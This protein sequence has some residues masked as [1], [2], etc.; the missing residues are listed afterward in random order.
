MLSKGRYYTLQYG[1]LQ[2]FYVRDDG[3]V[4]GEVGVVEGFPSIDVFSSSKRLY[5][6]FFFRY[7]KR[8]RGRS[9]TAPQPAL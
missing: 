8:V 1:I 4:W 9:L 6:V 3:L 2:S 7:T 5:E